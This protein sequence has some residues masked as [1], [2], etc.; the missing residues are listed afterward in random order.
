MAII[1]C[2]RA[3]R[4]AAQR[5]PKN[6]TISTKLLL[7]SSLVLATSTGCDTEAGADHP[8]YK[9]VAHLDLDAAGSAPW[10]RALLASHDVELDADGELGACGPVLKAATSITAGGSEDKFEVYVTG[11]FDSKTTDACID[12]IEDKASKSLGRHGH[13]E[14]E[15]VQLSDDLL[16]LHSSGLTPSRARMESLLD[17]DPSPAGQP[18]WIIAQPDAA[19]GKHQVGYVQAW[20]KTAGGLDAH[21]EVQFNDEARSTEL[22]GKAMLGLTALQLSGEMDGLADGIKLERKG[23]TLVAN[24]HLA[25]KKIA[26]MLK[27]VDTKHEGKS[28]KIRVQ[29]DND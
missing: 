24:L 15:V 18:M 23:D 16:A 26:S 21:V 14:P 9:A 5:S 10:V 8:D 6:V 1:F 27:E 2:L 11:A 7:A 19:R 4:I 28:I 13:D 25:P 20:A 3:L 29:T 17:S 22:Y 12:F